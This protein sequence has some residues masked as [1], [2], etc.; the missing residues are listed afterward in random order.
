MAYSNKAQLTVLA[1]DTAEAIGWGE[2]ASSLAEQLGDVRTIVHALNNVG[3]AHLQ[4]QH[5]HGWKLLER[6]LQLAL[7]HGFEEDAARAYTNLVDSALSIHDYPRARGY[8]E[9]GIAYCAEHDLDFWGMPLRI[10][11]AQ[12]LFE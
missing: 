6:S 4:D 5:A 9:A 12:A 8:L 7:E 10:S 2:R 1:Q 11:Q 3:T